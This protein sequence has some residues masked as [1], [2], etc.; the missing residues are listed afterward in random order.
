MDV[1][2]PSDASGLSGP[3]LAAVSRAH[4]I[5]WMPN[6]LL[7][8]NSRRPWMQ[9]AASILIHGLALW[10]IIDIMDRLRALE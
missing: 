3:A 7:P 4:Q 2:K 9:L 5:R 10:G 1:A 8:F 6:R